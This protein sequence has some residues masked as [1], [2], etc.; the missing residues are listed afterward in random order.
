MHEATATHTITSFY[1][2]RITYPSPIH[3]GYNLSNPRLA[4]PRC[5]TD[6]PQI[7]APQSLTHPQPQNLLACLPV[8][9]VQ[10]TTHHTTPPPHL[11]LPSIP[12]ISHHHHHHP[13]THHNPPPITS[14]WPPP[15]PPPPPL[16]SNTPPT[17]YTA[18]P[19]TSRAAAAPRAPRRT[20]AQS[21]TT[22]CTCC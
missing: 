4:F 22:H 2:H 19:P 15:P 17:S 6:P 16:H 18:T 8:I 5:N 14:P 13:P 1:S 7:A 3:T 10:Q 9:T 11:T 21:R 12:T 20:S